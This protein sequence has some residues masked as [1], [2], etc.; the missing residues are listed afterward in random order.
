MN[1]IYN[2]DEKVVVVRNPADANLV[3]DS[4]DRST[5]TSQVGG[6]LPVPQ[7]QSYNNFRLQKGENLMQGGFTRIQLSEI[8]FPYAIPN[9]NIT[10]NSFWIV[11]RTS[12]S[13]IKARI[14]IPAD[15][16]FLTGSQIAQYVNFQLNNS[17]V[18][19]TTWDATYYPDTPA[20]NTTQGSG[21][22]ITTSTSANAI[23]FGLYPVQPV[24][25]YPL[26]PTLSASADNGS[27][28]D[29]MGYNPLSN[30]N[31]L[32]AFNLVLPPETIISLSSIYAPLTYTKFIDI[33]SNKLTYYANVKDN[34]TNRTGL[35][36][37]ICRLYISD[38]TSTTPT[39]GKVYNGTSL[40]TYA[41]NPPAGSLP[42]TIH[43][44]FSNPKCFGWDMNTAIDWI[45]ISL[46]DDRGRPLYVPPEGL[47]DFQITF[48]CTED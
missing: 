34:S 8:R 47:P 16:V 37:I 3:L 9:V 5:S 13:D 11:L 22:S 27:L 32:T 31:Y 4:A 35:S 41:V 30:W 48:K 14:V 17:A 23:A 43:R 45:D 39:I 12:T 1:S 29:V 2:E 44:Q 20:S 40:I 21:F 6:I 19:I 38:E 26:A 33:V 28:L 24:L 18:G 36:N 42:F 46:F 10:N 25:N 15:P 7:A